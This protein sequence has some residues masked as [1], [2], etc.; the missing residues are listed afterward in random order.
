MLCLVELR[1]LSNNQD[2][3]M[4]EAHRISYKKSLLKD[5]INNFNVKKNS[6]ERCSLSESTYN[7]GGEKRPL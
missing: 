3:F 2:S 5:T 6:L 4:Q 1:L 7:V